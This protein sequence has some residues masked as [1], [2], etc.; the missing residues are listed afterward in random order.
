MKGDLFLYEWQYV[1]FY[2][3]AFFC[4]RGFKQKVVAAVKYTF[5]PTSPVVCTTLASK[6]TNMTWMAYNLHCSK[7]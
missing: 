2:I 1:T 5:T 4:L 6:D 3:P 7:H